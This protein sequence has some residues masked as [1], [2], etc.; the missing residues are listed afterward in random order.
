M[1]RT[2]NNCVGVQDL[3]PSKTGK[4]NHAEIPSYSC[5]NDYQQKSFFSITNTQEGVKD[6]EYSLPVGVETGATMKEI[7]VKVSL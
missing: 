1:K 7:S 6:Q 5:K 3:E 2:T 4:L